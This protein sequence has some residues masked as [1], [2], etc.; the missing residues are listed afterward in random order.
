MLMDSIQLEVVH[1]LRTR[2]EM[3][4]VTKARLHHLM[5]EMLYHQFVDIIGKFSED[6][7]HS[8]LLN[9]SLLDEV[10]EGKIDPRYLQNLNIPYITSLRLGGLALRERYTPCLYKFIQILYRQ[11]LSPFTNAQ[12]RDEVFSLLKWLQGRYSYLHTRNQLVNEHRI[13]ERYLLNGQEPSSFSWIYGQ[14]TSTQLKSLYMFNYTNLGLENTVKQAYTTQKDNPSE[15]FYHIHAKY[16][17]EVKTLGK[18][19]KCP[20]IVCYGIKYQEPHFMGTNIL[21]RHLSD[22]CQQ[23]FT[24]DELKTKHN[25]S[26]L[27]A[28]EALKFVQL[29]NKHYQ[30]TQE[31]QT[32]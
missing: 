11:E 19:V 25:I 26:L 2:H 17:Y 27:Q 6:E 16:W 32:A 10:L 9:E 21:L 18:Q 30:Q 12:G 29:L 20:I 8:I 23:G 28:R 24:E 22:D 31:L 1:Y 14:L 3:T 4:D 5:R 13:V 15:G 7:T